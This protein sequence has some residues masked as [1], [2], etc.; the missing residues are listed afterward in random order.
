MTDMG[1]RV[2]RPERLLPRFVG[3][4]CKYCGDGQLVETEYEG[5]PAVVCPECEVPRISFF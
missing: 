5:N 1:G 4:D 2:A 3:Q